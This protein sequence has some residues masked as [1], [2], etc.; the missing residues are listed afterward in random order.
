MHAL[1]LSVVWA[2]VVML[3][4]AKFSLVNLYINT[5]LTKLRP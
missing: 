1:P 2:I 3:L 4:T 5:G